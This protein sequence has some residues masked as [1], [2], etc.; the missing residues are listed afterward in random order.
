MRPQSNITLTLGAFNGNE[1]G[2]RGHPGFPMASIPLCRFRL[3]LSVWGLLFLPTKRD[4]G[5][6]IGEEKRERVAM[7]NSAD[8]TTSSFVSLVPLGK[9]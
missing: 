8:S 2:A 1:C 6:G 4:H 5:Q 7:A 3:A 9:S